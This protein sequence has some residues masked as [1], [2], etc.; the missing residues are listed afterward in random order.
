VLL[1]SPCKRVWRAWEVGADRLL[2]TALFA[3]LDKMLFFFFFLSFLSFFPNFFYFF[4]RF[5]SRV[6]EEE[7]LF[8]QLNCMIRALFVSFLSSSGILLAV[9]AAW[10]LLAVRFA[11]VGSLRVV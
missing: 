6:R 8:V 2:L 11:L 7:E 5:L 9:F 1:L 3:T 4:R 10:F